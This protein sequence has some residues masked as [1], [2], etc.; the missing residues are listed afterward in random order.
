MSRSSPQLAANWRRLLGRELTQ[1]SRAPVREIL[2]QPL[3]PIGTSQ[4]IGFT[5]PP[6][7]GKSSLVA[8]LAEHRLGRG[9][10]IGILAIDPTSP[11]SQGSLLGDRVRMDG[12]QATDDLYIR[13]VASGPCHDGL[14]RNA[15]GLMD[16]M[17]R[18]GF[19]DLVL[20]TVGIGQVSYEARVLVDTLALVLVPES[21]DTIQAMKAGILEM[22]DIYVIN[23]A[24][25]PA[26][27]RLSAELKSIVG[28]NHS[29]ENPIPDI[30]L[31]SARENKGIAE[32]D[33]ALERHH[34]RA[35]A[36]HRREKAMQDRANYQIRALMAQ[37][38]DELLQ[39]TPLKPA[40]SNL[41]ESY[42]AIARSISKEIDDV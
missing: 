23:K 33:A 39:E 30:I 15:T 36:A 26:A 5:G 8:R 3:S 25:T 18:Y 20:E 37:H 11:V 2:A 9:R 1:Q 17:E 31:T 35:M 42:R 16:T 14:C 32:L 21:G 13:S 38:V 7:A 27:E 10:R 6:G 34:V 24:E 22:A 29:D 4:R 12:I 19:D 40:A 28:R 41:T